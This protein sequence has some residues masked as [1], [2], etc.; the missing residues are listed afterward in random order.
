[1]NY[2]DVDEMNLKEIDEEIEDIEDEIEEM[3]DR[4]KELHEEKKDRESCVVCQ[5]GSWDN[6]S[7]D[8]DS[9]CSK[10]YLEIE[11]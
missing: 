6:Y 2:D 7:G 9:L 5:E 11:P 4:L 10:H 3:N 1:M 8:Y